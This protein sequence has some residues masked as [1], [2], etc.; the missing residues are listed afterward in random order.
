MV[1]TGSKSGIA[2]LLSSSC[3]LRVVTGLHTEI[4]QLLSRS[5]SLF[6]EACGSYRLA[7]WRGEE[8]SDNLLVAYINKKYSCI[9]LFKLF[10]NNMVSELF[11]GG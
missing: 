1:Q 9:Q 8:F 5:N 2:Q 7:L 11:K 3:Q 6:R 10:R 4:R